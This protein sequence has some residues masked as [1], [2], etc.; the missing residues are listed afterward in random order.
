M[1]SEHY[2]LQVSGFL[3]HVEDFALVWEHWGRLIRCII[4]EQAVEKNKHEAVQKYPD[5][6]LP[7]PEENAADGRFGAAS[8]SSAC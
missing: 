5:A 6:R 1:R 3:F 4:P 8:E 2:T 7:K